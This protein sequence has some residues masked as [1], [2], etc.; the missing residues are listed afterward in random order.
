MG[1]SLLCCRGWNLFV[2]GYLFHTTLVAAACF[3][4]GGEEGVHDLQRFLGADEVGGQT[5]HVGV[6]VL[7]SQFGQFRF[8]A[9]CGTDALVVVG[10]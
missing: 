1:Y 5:Q 3:E 8:P 4:I 6:V 9:Q 10:L 7:A 2:P